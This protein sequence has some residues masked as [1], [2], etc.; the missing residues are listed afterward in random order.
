M[1]SL[2]KEIQYAT[3]NTACNL[4]GM[5]P[6]Q[7]PD[8]GV[9]ATWYLYTVMGLS[10]PMASMTSTH[11]PGSGNSATVWNACNWRQKMHNVKS[12]ILRNEKN[13]TIK[14]LIHLVFMTGKGWIS[15]YKMKSL[16][17]HKSKSFSMHK[18]HKKVQTSIF[19]TGLFVA[20][21]QYRVKFWLACKLTNRTN[22]FGQSVD[23]PGLKV[24]HWK[25]YFTGHSYHFHS[26]P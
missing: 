22:T 17:A 26:L 23:I 25:M 1:G 14:K 18:T 8:W 4:Q 13:L 16:R 15:L 20:S 5:C 10:I 19:E 2:S 12:L 11:S 6:H 9:K 3:Q 21:H 24:L 7:E